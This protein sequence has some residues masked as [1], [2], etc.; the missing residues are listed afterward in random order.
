MRDGS[1]RNCP[2]VADNLFDFPRCEHGAAGHALQDEQ[3]ELFR[4]LTGEW[5]DRVEEHVTISLKDGERR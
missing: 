1:S 4:A 2:A 5:L 3:T